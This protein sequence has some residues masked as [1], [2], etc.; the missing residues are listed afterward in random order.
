MTP[1]ITRTDD[2]ATGD[3]VWTLRIPHVVTTDIYRYEDMR[4][5]VAVWILRLAAQA[6][7]EFP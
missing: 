7:E 2:P 4:R 1:T 3:A 6:L 5:Q